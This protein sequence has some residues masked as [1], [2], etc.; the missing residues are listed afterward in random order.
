MLLGLAVAADAAA[1]EEGGGPKEAGRARWCGWGRSDRLTAAGITPA[2][3][4]QQS[5]AIPRDAQL[6]FALQ[7]GRDGR[8]GRPGSS[9]EWAGGLMQV[10]IPCGLASRRAS[11]VSTT[12]AAE[13]TAWLV[14]LLTAGL[15]V[16]CSPKQGI[17]SGALVNSARAGAKRRR[18][19]AGL[20]R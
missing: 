15:H 12:G 3:V 9:H 19:S 17:V 11:T 6:G 8:R 18:G 10:T 13:A 20:R 14:Q 7:A 2:V 5:P 4:G 1:A 16:P